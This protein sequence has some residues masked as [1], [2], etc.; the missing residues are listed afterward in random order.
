MIVDLHLDLLLDLAVRRG[1]GER[2][3]FR[4]RYREVLEAGGVRVQVLPTFVDDPLVPEAALRTVLRQIDAAW[5]E[6]EESE[7]ALRIVTT[8][9]ELAE[10]LEA[11]AVAGI[12]ALEGVEALG[13]EPALIATLHRL[14]VRMAGLT[15]N[16]SNDFADGLAEDRGVG[17]TP[18][19]IELLGEMQRLGIALDLSHL[20]PHGCEV[21]LG[22]FGGSVCASHANA[23]A[24][25]RNP[26]NLAD[27]VL[28]EVGRR[29]GVVGVNCIPAFLGPG[30]PIDRAVAHHDHI[31]SVA[32]DGAPAFGADFCD[33]LGGGDDDVPLLPEDPTEEE[34]A[35]A[36][37]P[38]PPRETFY[39][40]VLGRLGD[41]VRTP[42]AEGNALRFLR[43]VLR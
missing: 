6:Q 42:L 43:G 25:A 3:V 13:R 20:T 30:D 15:W 37:T 23:R 14:G 39:A 8:G 29:G 4:R 9:A 21:A 16:R 17:V 27:D 34:L 41:A 36:R 12:L 38:E 10:A 5:R 22:A 31:A 40:D 32:G 18:L 2:D 26:R 1:L 28:A 24:V 19:G 11:G 35:H 33:W 7:G